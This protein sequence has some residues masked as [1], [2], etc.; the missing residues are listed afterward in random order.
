MTSASHVVTYT[1]SIQ[2]FDD[3]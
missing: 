2:C 3:V 1:Q